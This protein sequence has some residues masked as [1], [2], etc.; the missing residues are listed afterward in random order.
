MLRITDLRLPLDHPPEDL[1]RAV[2]ARLG[3]DDGRL[4]EMTVHKRSYDARK[5][6][7]I[8]LIYTVDCAIAGDEA[9]VLAAHPGDSHLRAAPDMG[10]RFVASAPADFAIGSARRPIV[11]GFGPCG[12]F[13][14]LVLAQ[15]GLAADR[16][17]A[18][19]GGARAHRA[20]PGAC[21]ARACSIRSRTC[22]SAKAAPAPSRTASC[23]ARSATRAT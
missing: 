12:I 11:V 1:R 7:A 22:S 13:C 21:G 4:L 19:Q 20:T 9:A 8:V 14:A 16:A 10:Y 5:K 3:I 2:V 17:R 18:R 6:S 23:G 15:M